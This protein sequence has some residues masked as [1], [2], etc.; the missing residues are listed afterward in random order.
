M[1]VPVVSFA[2]VKAGMP[3]RQLF[4]RAVLSLP[5][6]FLNQIPRAL[7]IAGGLLLLAGCAGKADEAGDAAAANLITRQDFE[8]VAG[9]NGAQDAPSLTTEKAHSGK[10]ALKVGPGVDYSIGYIHPMGQMAPKRFRK[11]KISGWFLRPDAGAKATLIFSVA[12]KGAADNLVWAGLNVHD[13][14]SELN[15]WTRAELEVEVPA[16]AQFDDECR[17]YLWR[18]DPAA[19]VVYADD[20]E[21]Q[22]VE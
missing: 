9:W 20:L 3:P 2:A 7:A 12:H 1:A 19:T 22:V 14:V 6:A 21:I 18:S 8:S 10:Y 4:S 15:T 11:L 13:K 16:A 17:F 5:T